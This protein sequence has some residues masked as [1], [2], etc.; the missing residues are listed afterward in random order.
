[1]AYVIIRYGRYTGRE[2]KD[3]EEWGYED[4]KK[5]DLGIM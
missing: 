5:E 3:N 1:M 2:L 4:R